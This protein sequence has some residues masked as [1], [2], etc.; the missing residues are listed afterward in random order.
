[1]YAETNSGSKA[2]HSSNRAIA[3]ENRGVATST[4]VDGQAMLT[5]D[6]QTTGVPIIVLR[7]TKTWIPG[8]LVACTLRLASIS[9]TREPSL[10]RGLTLAP[11]NQALEGN[12]LSLYIRLFMRPQYL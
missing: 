3:Y 7:N 12:S 4:L 5:L 11:N 8:A 1:M 10:V 9:F 6:S 2:I